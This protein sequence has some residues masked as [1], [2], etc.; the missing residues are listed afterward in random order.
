MFKP[1]KIKFKAQEVDSMFCALNSH[2]L[3]LDQHQQFDFQRFDLRVEANRCHAQELL[4]F[5]SDRYPHS[6]K[7]LIQKFNYAL[8]NKKLLAYLLSYYADLASQLIYREYRGSIQKT[9][10]DLNLNLIGCDVE[11]DGFC[12]LTLETAWQNVSGHI[13]CEDYALSNHRSL[14]FYASELVG[15]CL[16]INVSEPFELALRSLLYCVSNKSRLFVVSADQSD[17]VMLSLI[18]NLWP[19]VLDLPDTDYRGICMLEEFLTLYSKRDD[20]TDF[21][22]TNYLGDL[23]SIYEFN[24]SEAGDNHNFQS[25]DELDVIEMERDFNVVVEWVKSKLA[26][27]R[28]KALHSELGMSG[29]FSTLISD[30]RVN[31]VSVEQVNLCRVF[32][33][34]NE[35]DCAYTSIMITDEIDYS[36]ANRLSLTNGCGSYLGS[37]KDSM[38][39]YYEDLL[40]DD[41]YAPR[42]HGHMFRIDKSGDFVKSVALIKVLFSQLGRCV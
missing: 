42:D 34:L 5:Y 22:L 28:F 23:A 32:R 27:Y 9:I 29:A 25:F 7:N 26:A 8:S 33:A 19:R 39:S 3:M 4:S 11:A 20:A 21:I 2:S 38:D 10:T 17:D 18:G 36:S 12:N 13:A 35:V 16:P 24:L 14:R 1:F 15:E 37:G 30:L 40:R 41:W 6:F 31:A